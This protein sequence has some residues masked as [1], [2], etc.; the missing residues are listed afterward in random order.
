MTKKHVW[1][2]AFEVWI[3]KNWFWAQS[4]CS[5]SE[6]L[7]EHRENR[8]GRLTELIFPRPVQVQL[9]PDLCFDVE[10]L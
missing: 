6:A 2:I 9:E 3:K 7:A 1:I 4:S 5:P 10:N 8:L